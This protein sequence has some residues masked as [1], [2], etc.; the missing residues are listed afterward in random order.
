MTTRRTLHPIFDQLPIAAVAFD[1]HDTLVRY[2]D[3]DH[4]LTVEI[5]KCCPT[6][7]PDHVATAWR[8]RLHNEPTWPIDWQPDGSKDAPTPLS[9]RDIWAERL[10]LGGLTEPAI[11]ALVRAWAER[12]AQ[13]PPLEGAVDAV[14]AIAQRLPTAIVSNGDTDYV[15]AAVNAAPFRVTAVIPSQAAGAPKPTGHIFRLT[16][17]RLDVDPGSILFVGD[18]PRH[19]MDGARAAGLHTTWKRP[20]PTAHWP[21]PWQP[22]LTIDSVSA[23]A[24]PAPSA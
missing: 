19:D 4:F 14:Q 18:S 5:P 22:A 6:L 9:L 23:L 21:R 1:L 13:A 24:P 7:D 16:A 15:T 12:V 17:A 3:I 10:H 2:P 20:T 11:T 8:D